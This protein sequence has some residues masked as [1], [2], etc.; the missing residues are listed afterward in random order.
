MAIHVD[1]IETECMSLLQAQGKI[2]DDERLQRLF[3]VAWRYRM[4]EYPEWATDLNFPGHN[5]RWRDNSA[6]AIAQRPKKSELFHRVLKSVDRAA[7][8]G[9]NQLSYELFLRSLNE[10]IEGYRFKQDFL[11]ITQISGLHQ[12]LAQTL[13]KMPVGTVAQCEDVIARLNA[14]PKAV[15]EVVALLKSGLATGVTPPKITLR[16]VL[17]QVKNQMVEDASSA[18]MLKVLLELPGSIPLTEQEQVRQHAYAAYRDSVVPAFEKLHVFLEKEYLPGCRESVSMA[19][20]PDGQAWY[21]YAVKR[22]TT[23]NLTPQQIHEIGLA[24]VK[25][26]RGEMDRIIEEVGFKGSFGDFCQFLRTDSQFFYTEPEALLTGYRDICKRVDPELIRMF[27]HL[28]CLP[29]G[30]IPIPSYMEKSQTTAY[31]SP[32]SLKAGRPGYYYANTY[33]LASRPKWEM[34]ALTLHEAVPGHHFQIAISQELE[35]LPE[36]RK[37]NWVTAYGEGWALYA[38]SLGEEM[39]FYRD[40]YSKF[41]QLTY[42]MWRAIRLVVDPG[43]HALGWTRQQAIDYFKANS[44]KTEHDITVEID[45]YIVWPGQAVAYKIGE[46]KI[47]EIRALAESELGEAFDIR[48]FHDELLAHGGLPLDVLESHMKNWIGRQGKK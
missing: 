5:H 12:D 10:E 28:P 29:Y 17:R 1:R 30:V 24:E 42:E 46:L 15:D 16:E 7:L 39:G 40:P 27:R 26:I 36:F 47:K 19:D 44:C 13:E 9:E 37:H 23:T 43:L 45:R 31:Y 3:D 8:N 22:Y 32:G 41:G 48:T 2:S 25:R 4:A 18:P 35:D 34:E 33:D 21:A 14:V 11:Q 20:L 6:E 38:E